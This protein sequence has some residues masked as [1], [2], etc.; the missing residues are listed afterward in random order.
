MS[1]Q[2]TSLL[3]IRTMLNDAGVN[4]TRYSTQRL[5]ELLITSAYFLPLEINF[6]TT[7][8]LMNFFLN[9]GMITNEKKDLKTIVDYKQ[10]IVFS[11]MESLMYGTFKIPSDWDSLTYEQKNE[12]LD[13]TIASVT[14]KE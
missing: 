5:E 7:I 10:R 6:N 4:D 12:R 9:I 11:T 2:N 8:K 1:W 13:K 14:P 3:M